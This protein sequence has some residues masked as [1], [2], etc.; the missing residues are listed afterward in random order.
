MSFERVRTLHQE[1]IVLFGVGLLIVVAIATLVFQQFRA[2]QAESTKVPDK[3]PLSV[4]FGDEAATQRVI[5]YTDPVCDRCAAY[6]EDV[7]KPL[8][9]QYVKTGK[10]RLEMRPIGI[11]SA[12]S[13][14]LNELIMC[15]NEQDRYFGATKYVYDAVHGGTDAA[16][17]A[18]AFF[19]IH[20]SKDIATA[21]KIDQKKLD[22]C[23]DEN[24]Y[25]TKMSQADAQAYAS[26]IYSAP[27]TIIGSSEPVRGYSTY[28]YITS[29][30][31]LELN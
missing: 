9:E 1:K 22:T 12:D 18:T 27:T 4:T 13:A 23:L 20:S 24:P 19:S 21:L 16:Q 7:V 5:V 3:A 29:L 10:I 31:E 30:V 6:H 25:N 2:Q 14:K 26:D 28:S 15:S 8:Y 17:A 11:V